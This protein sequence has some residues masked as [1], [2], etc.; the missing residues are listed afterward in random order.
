MASFEDT[1]CKPVQYMNVKPFEIL[2]QREMMEVAVVT[3]EKHIQIIYSQLHLRMLPW[4][5]SSVIL[6]RP[7]SSQ[8]IK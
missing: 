5:R 4:L 3:T 8:P 1:L 2:L 6:P 7:F